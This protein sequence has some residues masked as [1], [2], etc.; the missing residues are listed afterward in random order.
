MIS[1]AFKMWD[2]LYSSCFKESTKHLFSLQCFHSKEK[3]QRSSREVNFTAIR[4]FSVFLHLAE[5]SLSDVLFS[6]FTCFVHLRESFSLLLDHFFLFIWP[7]WV[8][9]SYLVCSMSWELLLWMF[10]PVLDRDKEPLKISCYTERWTL[11]DYILPNADRVS[12]D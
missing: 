2:H 1:F 9:L 5:L 12:L 10:F 6:L 7:F 4:I 3:L 11:W 8:V